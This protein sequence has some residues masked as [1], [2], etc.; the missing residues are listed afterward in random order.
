MKK[1]IEANKLHTTRQA[2]D[3]LEVTE[4]T[5]QNYLRNGDLRGRKLGPRKKWHI[6]GSELLRVI[7]KWGYA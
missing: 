2:A 1:K 5:V 6:L 4:Q 7:R 3:I